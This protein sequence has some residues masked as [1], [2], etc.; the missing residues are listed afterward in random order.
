MVSIE[1]LDNTTIG[2]EGL[3]PGSVWMT[4]AIASPTIPSGSRFAMRSRQRHGSRTWTR[5]LPCD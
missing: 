5:W 2:I 3:E 4:A 1:L